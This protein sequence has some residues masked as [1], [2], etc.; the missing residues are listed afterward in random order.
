[1]DRVDDSRVD[2]EFGGSRVADELD[3]GGRER[4]A[5]RAQER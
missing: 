3:P 5:E 1:M 2:R 4:G